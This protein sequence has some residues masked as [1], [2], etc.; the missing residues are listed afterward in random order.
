MTFIQEKVEALFKDDSIR[1]RKFENKIKKALTEALEEGK[2]MACAEI[3][4]RVEQTHGFTS[5]N[6]VERII[7]ERDI[8][9]IT[10]EIANK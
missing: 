10:K 5:P 1:S 8:L 6:S 4:K 9:T 2:R 7:K 3:E